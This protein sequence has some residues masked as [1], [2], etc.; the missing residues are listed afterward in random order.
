[1][2]HDEVRAEGRR[3]WTPICCGSR[4]CGLSRS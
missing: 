1:M 2:L 3:R 4:T